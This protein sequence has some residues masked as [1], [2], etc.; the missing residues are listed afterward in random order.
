MHATE[1]SVKEFLNGNCINCM[2][3]P[4]ENIYSF[5]DTSIARASGTSLKISTQIWVA[6]QI[7]VAIF[8]STPSATPASRAPHYLLFL[9]Y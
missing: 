7:W 4:T 5:R 6:A 1:Q 8:I 2:C 9:R 3:H